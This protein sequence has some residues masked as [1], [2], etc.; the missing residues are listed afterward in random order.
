MASVSMGLLI[1]AMTKSGRLVGTGFF[2]FADYTLDLTLVDLTVGLGGI[3][4]GSQQQLGL[5]LQL[6]W[7]RGSRWLSEA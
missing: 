6:L 4:H 7:F 3:D 2:K 1:S 5:I